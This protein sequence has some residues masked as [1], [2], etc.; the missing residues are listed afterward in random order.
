MDP[1]VLYGGTYKRLRESMSKAMYGNL[2]EEIGESTQ[3]CTLLH[4]LV[5]SYSFI[6]MIVEH[7]A[8]RGDPFSV[9]NL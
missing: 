9:G 6:H 3:V 7:K 1:F 4:A 5:K 2:I 8:T